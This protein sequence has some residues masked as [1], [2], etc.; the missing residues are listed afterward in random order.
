MIDLVADAVDLAADFAG[1]VPGNK[2]VNLVNPRECAE[3]CGREIDVRV[4]KKLLGKLNDGSVGA[5][6]VLGCAAL[7]AESRDNLD[8]EVDLIRQQ[9]GKG[10]RSSEWLARGA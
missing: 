3:G 4:N 2:V 7:G 8:D 10:R 5:A 6:D 9:R 1:D